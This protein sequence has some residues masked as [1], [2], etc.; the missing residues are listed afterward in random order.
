MLLGIDDVKGSGKKIAG[1]ITDTARQPD[2]SY[3]WS[4]RIFFESESD[5][6][7][8]DEL[9]L[10]KS[11]LVKLLAKA[12]ELKPERKQKY[13]LKRSDFYTTSKV[14]VMREYEDNYGNS[15]RIVRIKGG[16]EYRVQWKRYGEN[17]KLMSGTD[18]LETAIRDIETIVED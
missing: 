8:T 18:D 5:Y 14:Y 6:K 13:H 11:D 17:Y 2:G 12:L 1:M 16:A 15:M 9:W 3:E 10:T 4:Y 7:I